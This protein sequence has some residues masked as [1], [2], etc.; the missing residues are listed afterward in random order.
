ML[1]LL[2]IWQLRRLRVWRGGGYLIVSLITWVA[3]YESG[4]HATLAGVLIALLLPVYPPK[5]ALVERAAALTSAFRQSPNPEYARSARLGLERAVSVNERLMRLYQPYT[6]F[7]IVPMFALANAGVPLTAETLR[8]SLT[9]PLTWG[10]VLGLVLGKFVG[11][12]AAT[13]LFARLR[14]GSLAP[15]LRIPQVAGGAALSGIG[16]TISLFI[17][18]LAL[19]DAP[20]LA[21]EARVGVLAASVIALVLGAGVFRIGARLGLEPEEPSM[22]LLRPVDPHRDH[23]RGPVDAPLTIVEYGDFECPF[24]SKATGSIRQVRAHF[25]DDV[26]YVFRHMPLDDYHPDA[27]SAAEVSEAAAKQGR[28]WDVHDAF[29]AHNDALGREDLLRYCAELGLDV[30]RIEE[31]LRAGDVQNRVAD[32]EIDARTSELP[33]TPTFYLGANGSPP[34]RHIGPYDA[35]TLIAELTRQREAAPDPV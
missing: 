24:C 34:M 27:R 29:F 21:D 7:I 18:D 33:G 31:D 30:D 25:G 8:A 13:A 26:R 11:I 5:R 9:S 4:V 3:F 35:D 19:D 2:A 17:V 6:A 14:P 15:G 10:V 12:T 23:I 20:L 28:F 22:E 32:D 16:F 1:G